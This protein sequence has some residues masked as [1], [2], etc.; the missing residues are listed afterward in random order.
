MPV[1]NQVQLITYPDSLGGDLKALEQVLRT[2]LS[3]A[4]QGGL[5]VLPP[6]PS[7]GDRGF[8]PLSYFEIDPRFGSWDDLQRL[9]ERYD[10]VLDLMVNHVSRQS[11][12]FQD[13]LRHGRR[14][15]HAD[16]FITRDKV[17]PAG[18]PPREDLERLFL[19]RPEPFSRFEIQDTGEVE[20]IWTTFGL[21]TPSEQIDLDL[22]SAGAREILER[23]LV[24]F[25]ERNVRIVRLDAVGYVVKKAGTSCFFVEPEIWGHLRW[26]ADL[27]RSLGL[28]VLPE[29]HAPRTTQYALAARGHWIYDFILPFLVLD[30]LL[31]GRSPRLQAYL[32][33]R[34]H[35]QFTVLDCHDG[36]P[37]KPDLDGLVE[38]AEARRVVDASLRRGGGVSR[39]LSSDHRDPE[40]FD[41]HQILVTYYSALGCDDDAYLAARA[42]QLFTP[43]VPQIYYVGLLAGEND[44][45]AVRRA[46]GEGRAVNRHDYTLPEIEEAVRR[47]VVQ[48]LLRLLRLRNTHPAFGGTFRVL[49][50][51]AGTLRLSWS[52]ADRRCSLEVDLEAGRSVVRYDDE[53]GASV[54]HRV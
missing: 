22:R 28:E 2:H 33:D 44:E 15:R 35:H 40:G 46:A 14:S 37:V 42:I 34:P 5:H 20:Q 21:E 11:P 3:E 1:K 9:G 16:L 52:K 50:S 17:W 25:A 26:L 45:G 4:C 31:S 10:V 18:D 6:F 24:H 38:P 36:I 39:V 49:E 23:V 27:A 19:R 12:F 7:S 13:F 8:A 54:E 48:R 53:A 32:R 29:V 43:G 30:A 41:V 47:P 51:D